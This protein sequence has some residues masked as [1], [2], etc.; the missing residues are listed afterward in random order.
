MLDRV[1]SRS[2]HSHRP[3]TAFVGII[4]SDTDPSD[5]DGNR[6]TPERADASAE[7]IGLR[8]LVVED[9]FLLGIMTEEELLSLG[10][11]VLGPFTTLSAASEAI[12]TEEFDI[13]ILDINLDGQMVFPLAD[14]LVERGIPFLFLTGYA[15]LTIP[16]RLRPAPRLTKPLQRAS[17]VKAMRR[18]VSQA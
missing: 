15:S 11:E 4:A 2:L 18:I 10:C 13:A 9:E 16:E 14:R 1:A 6:W 5:S 8:V 3:L 17:L 12:R 7:L